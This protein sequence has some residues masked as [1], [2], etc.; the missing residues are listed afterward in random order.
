MNNNTKNYLPELDYVE[1]NNEI[2]IGIDL[3]TRFSC[4]SVWRNKRF[5][6]I[7]DQFGNRTIP[8]VVSYYKSAK[9]V[10]NNALSM[11]D[12][13]PKNT[14]YDIKR[15]I[16]RRINDASIK[17]TKKLISYN[18]VDD[19]SP[20]HN[21]LIELD[22]QDINITRKKLYKPEEICAQILMEIKKMAENYLKR[23]V[24]KAVITVPAY[25]ND[26]QRQATLDASKIAGLDVIKIINE[27]TA[28]SLAYGLG[29]KSWKNKNG[30]NIIIYD[31][32]AGTLDVCL[33]NINN[34]LFRTLA[35]SGSTHLG[36]EDIDYL[37]MNHVIIDFQKKYK[38]RK[39]E[40]SKLA[41][42]K[43]KNAVENAKKLLST[44]EKTV[45]CV[46][47]F[48]NGKKIY[49]V[50]SRQLFE[51]ICNDLFI[52][53]IKPIKD[54]LESANLTCD[55]I[56]DVIL[57]GG[58]TRIPK[59]QSLILEYFKNTNI[60]SLTSSLNPD[61]VV[62]AGASI[63]GYIM[64]HNE[65]P[66]SENLVLLDI[67]PLSLGVETLQRQMTTIIP[68]NTVIPTKKTKI[69]STDT[70][71]QDT[72]SIKIFE[73][74]RK[75]TKHNFHVGTFDL[76][77][78]EKGPRGYP[79][80]KITFQ[81]D[82]NGILQVTAHEKKSGV[83]NGIQITSTWGAKGR[84]SRKEIDDIIKQA[85]KHEEIDKMYSLKIGLVHKINS[86]CNSILINLRDD[87]YVLTNADKKKIKKD[88]HNNLNWISS[89]EFN[90]LE[91]DELE[92]REIRLSK[93]YAPL[94]AQINKNNNKF[95]DATTASNT[96]EIHGDDD[97]ND[98]IEKYE[99]IEIPND[100]SE[101]D[102]E[103]IKS[104]KKT[105]S[106][107]CKNITSV[108]NN[109]V[110]RFSNDDIILVTDYLESVQIWLYT[111]NATT[112]IEFI[113]KIDEINKFTEDVMK[114]YEDIKIFEK[115]ENFTLRDELQLTCLTLNTSI[116]SNYFSLAKNDIDTLLKIIN[117]TM[118]WLLDHQ[119][120][121]NSV[122]QHKIDNIS[123]LCNKIYHNMHKLQTISDIQD[124]SSDSDDDIDELDNTESQISVN[125]I[126][127]NIDDVLSILPEKINDNNNS[128]SDI[129]LK[130]DMS[131][132]NSNKKIKYKN[133][134]H[135][136]R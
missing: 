1:Q 128:N 60:K 58:S 136:Y 114:K 32:G 26:A 77:G 31:L 70:D 115:N 5:E 56:D 113:A 111:T 116:K 106:D 4:V 101:Y 122:Y 7:P 82:I 22:T 107:L 18:L 109:P 28:A 93:T 11:K 125:K 92:K 62:S 35:V 135:H 94:I 81:I 133:I 64:T 96:A 71:Y 33:M 66:F 8:S 20:H 40:F 36:G 43:L 63:Y 65:D 91:L 39:L 12:I 67:T 48:Y 98:N 100:P 126:K 95:K 90:D 21:I 14:I 47:D 52:M 127:E 50:L 51:M 53:C 117:E 69:F 112:T 120:E 85:E 37:I 89:R 78:F 131:K 2:V 105:I 99:K 97:D 57:V 104:L 121:Q 9:L 75:L 23:Q 132:L 13:N 29:S 59:I 19:D 74:E 86:I 17:Q 83:E 119:N 15:I 45:I 24:E 30:G 34:G 44:V 49:F 10:G 3:G 124:I 46:D 41:Q 72:V 103:E 84:L 16:G 118:M 108:V 68:R 87:A 73:G 42:L 110:S 54:V 6:I 123:E 25:F 88:V 76:T 79:T 27:P 129:L 102:K 38:I 134:E 55:D 61:E 130:I 80:I